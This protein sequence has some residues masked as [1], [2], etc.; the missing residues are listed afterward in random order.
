MLEIAFGQPPP[1]LAH[2][3]PIRHRIFRGRHSYD[4]VVTVG[5]NNFA[6]AMA[7]P[8]GVATG[9]DGPDASSDLVAE[10]AHP[11][12]RGTEVLQAVD[13]DGPLRDLGLVVA[14]VSLTF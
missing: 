8:D 10:H 12:V 7:Q 14:G 2:Q 5:W 6:G 1:G 4:C 9:A 11:T 3:L 13:G